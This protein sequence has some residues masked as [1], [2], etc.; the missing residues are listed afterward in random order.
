[1]LDFT[2]KLGQRAQQ[3]IETEEII[4]LTTV[5][6]K[7]TPQPRPVWFVWDGEAFVIY[8]QVKAKKVQHIAKNPNIALHFDSGENGEDVQVFFGVAEIVQNPMPANQNA[9]YMDKYRKGI[10]GLGFTEQAFSAEYSVK[11]H[12][13]PSR[14]R[15]F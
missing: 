7:G 4:W 12:V 15:S 11:I 10:H 2:T 14:L 1:M 6:V 9:A 13:K 5:D 3:R 8:S